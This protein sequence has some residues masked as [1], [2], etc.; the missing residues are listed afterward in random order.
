VTDFNGH[1]ITYEYDA[2][3]RLNVKVYP[4]D[5][6]QSQVS[7]QYTA[8]GQIESITQGSRVTVFSYDAQDRLLSRTD[9]DG[10]Y[11]PSGETIKYEYD[12]AGNR[13]K[14]ITPAGEVQYFYDEQN[15]LERVVDAESNETR[16]FY[17]AANNL[18]RTELPNGTIESRTYDELNRLDVIKYSR[19]DAATNQLVE[20]AK[21][22]YSLDK[23]GYRQVVEERNGRK[24][25]YEYDDLY[26]LKK[27]V[28]TDAVAGNRTIEFEYDAVGNRTKQKDSVAGETSYFYDDNDRLL[29]EELRQNGTL[30]RTIY[31]EYDDN[32][33]TTKERV[34]PVSGAFQETTFI[35]DGDNRLVGVQKPNGD[36]IS[37]TYDADGI[38]VSSTVNGVTTQYLVDKNRDYAQVLEERANDVLNASYVYGLDL[39]SQS[40]GNDDSFYLVDGL[41]STR[42]LTDV[43]EVVT[44]SYSY[45]AFWNLIASTGNIENDYLFAGEQY[46]ADLSQYYLRQRYYNPSLGRFTRADSYEG[47]RR[48]PMSRHDY[49]YGN[50]NPVNY[51]DPSGLN[52]TLMDFTVMDIIIGALAAIAEVSWVVPTV[53][54]LT[55]IA[56]G[57]FLTLYGIHLAMSSSGDDGADREGEEDEEDQYPE[58]EHPDGDE[59]DTSEDTLLKDRE[60][61]KLQEEMARQ[62]DE[63]HE[64]KGGKNAAHRDLFKDSEGR[65]YA[66]PKGQH[67]APGTFIGYNINKI[68]N[69]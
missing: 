45:D 28:I 62:G 50:A 41:G 61:R 1:T 19:L 9:S 29:G 33:N 11:L 22:D 44:D 37:Y 56:I 14:V 10:Q 55:S 40:R 69:K 15:R 20:I 32:G 42:G 49:L 31:Y 4:V 35:W 51:I 24:V 30:Q 18:V 67:K 3:N 60:I 17:D 13:T 6:G 34:V 5:S 53:K 65:V 7:Y 63:I 27:E 59:R 39:I 52:A 54:L 8:T 43:N 36:V 12:A 68:M 26:R 57:T 47:R 2:Q 16:Y 23:V 38:R 48:N 21:F 25:Q 46:D 64:S 66:K 58:T